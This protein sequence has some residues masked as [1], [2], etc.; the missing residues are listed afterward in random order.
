M[1][2]LLIKVM[3]QENNK[4]EIHVHDQATAVVVEEP[5]LVVYAGKSMLCMYQLRDVLY[6]GG[7][8]PKCKD[9]MQLRSPETG[10]RYITADGK[11][12]MSKCLH[13]RGFYKGIC[14]TC[15]ATEEP[16]P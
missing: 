5:F 3:D 11:P 2:G 10:Q 16:R 15:M 4:A 9:S 8:C 6:V 12:V 1:T 7:R 13:P 14:T